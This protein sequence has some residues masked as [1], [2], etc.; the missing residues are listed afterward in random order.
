[1]LT[2]ERGTGRG[3]WATEVDRAVAGRIARGEAGG[4]AGRVLARG[5][6]WVVEDVV[7]TSGPTDRPFEERHTG[8]SIAVVVAG[9]FQ[10]RSPHGREVLTP[11]SLLLGNAGEPFECG[12]EHAPGDRCVAFHYE[13]AYFE[14]IAADVGIGSAGGGF[15]APRLPPVREVSGAVAAAAA[16]V[17]G[18]HGIGW[19]ELAVELAARALGLA[20][21][22][23]PRPGVVLPGVQARVTEA[24]RRI[25]RD[26]AARLPLQGLAAE[27]GLSPFHFLRTFQRATG[28]TP[29]Q[30]ILRA[31]LREAAAQLAIGRRAVLAIA[32]DAGFGDLS[33][34]NRAFRA[35]FGV[36]PTKWRRRG[37]MVR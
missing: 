34:F 27:A 1:M 3:R 26:P 25:E 37:A 2:I 29:H 18:G 13:P 28:V 30:F 6:G 15:R 11:G 35:E 17:L 36:S 24:V 16:G 33:N 23:S 8:F 32:L 4:T 5:A 22:G 19:E 9:T 14:R 10:Y 31:R 12:H 20:S 7:C 21:G